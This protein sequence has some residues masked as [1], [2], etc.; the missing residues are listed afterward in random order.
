MRLTV[1]C[2]FLSLALN[3]SSWAERGDSLANRFA[4]SKDLLFS[5]LNLPG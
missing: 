1:G 2:L 3:L 5:L 4:E